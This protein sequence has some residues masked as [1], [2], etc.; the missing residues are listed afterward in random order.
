LVVVTPGVFVSHVGLYSA[1]KDGNAANT[2]GDVVDSGA[3]SETNKAMLESS[4][5]GA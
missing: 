1:G 5:C 3:A 4:I 2:L